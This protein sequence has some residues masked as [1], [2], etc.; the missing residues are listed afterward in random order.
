[1]NSAYYLEDEVEAYLKTICF[2][3]SNPDE[4]IKRLIGAFPNI[5]T[6]GLFD[7]VMGFIEHEREK[8]F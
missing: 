4:V 5:E 1:M 6:K 3:G 7:Y 8:Q 2:A